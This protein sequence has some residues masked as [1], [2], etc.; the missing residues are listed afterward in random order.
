MLPVDR[1][2]LIFFGLKVTNIKFEHIPIKECGEPLL[3]LSTQPFVLEAAYYNQGLSDD[4]KLYARQQ[5]VEKLIRLQDQMSG[6]RFKIWDPWRSRAV[7]GNIY[8]KFWTEVAT[9][10]PG[11]DKPTLEL[12]VGK[13]VTAPYNPNRIPPHATGGAIDLTLVGPDG[14]ELE[15]GTKFDHFGPEAASM[16]FEEP[17]RDPRI[18]DNRRMLREAMLSEDFRHDDEEWW[19]YDFGNQIWAAALDRPFAI[20][21][22]M[23]SAPLSLIRV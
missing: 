8:Q 3:D 12:E 21:G 10:H 16:Y 23:K 18:R 14:K 5:I 19:H 4:P 13:F 1:T 22:E 11:W 17:Q 6:Y 7:Q 15:M 20:Y 2:G 9:A